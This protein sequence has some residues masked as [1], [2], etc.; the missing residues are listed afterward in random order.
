MCC[1][2]DQRV[3]V[4]GNGQ[5]KGL[6]GRGALKV[7]RKHQR[8][9]PPSSIT[10]CAIVGRMESKL[11]VERRS[12]ISQN[13]LSFLLW[14]SSSEIPELNFAR[15]SRTEFNASSADLCFR[16]EMFQQEPTK[17]PR[18]SSRC[19][20]MRNWTKKKKKRRRKKK[21]RKKFV[22]NR[23][24]AIKSRFYFPPRAESKRTRAQHHQVHSRR[25]PNEILC[26]KLVEFRV[27]GDRLSR[28]Y[29]IF[30]ATTTTFSVHQQASIVTVH[31]SSVAMVCACDGP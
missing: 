4:G 21:K 14:F 16:S 12:Q 26:S 5:Q 25:N 9:F 17:F 11:W 7:Y 3:F 29:R 22:S 6:V 27:D 24:R 23:L 2:F 1:N 19:S 30:D 8:S 28:N 10:S 13:S 20:K 18:I 31:Y 15:R